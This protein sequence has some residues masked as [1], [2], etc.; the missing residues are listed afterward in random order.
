MSP[1]IHELLRTLGLALVAPL[2]LG[3]AHDV[4]R[5]KNGDVV[6]GRIEKIDDEKVYIDPTFSDEISIKFK[7]IASIETTRPVTITLDD[8]REIT[9][10]VELAP[11]GRMIVRT[12]PTRW[13][14]QQ[15][16]RRERFG[17]PPK[18]AEPKPAQE[19]LALADVSE[20]E[21]SYYRYEASVELGYNASSGNSD[22]SSLDLDAELEPSWGPNTLR[23]EADAERRTSNDSLS[24]DNWKLTFQYERDLPGRWLGYGVSS[25][26]SDPFQELDLRTIV[27]AGAGYEVYD[28]PT[29][30]LTFYAGPGYLKEA[31]SAGS[32]DRSSFGFVLATKF[33]QDLFS[34]D[35][36]L[37]HENQLVKTVGDSQFVAQTVQ[38][39]E[40]DLLSNLDLKLELDFDH[41]QD[42]PAGVEKK[43][44][45]RYVV[46]LEYEF[47]GDET[48]W[49]H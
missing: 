1:R 18:A 16:R 42:P 4:V 13:E 29:R 14:E 12:A 46:K 34:S 11:D 41:T 40:L 48:D 31:F 2:C 43:N 19:P 30:D 17:L 8:E 36:T 5:M 39:I 10:Y 28:T 44:D 26:E 33:E 15:R 21:L 38:G 27:A 37:Y 24:A 35:V 45:L 20:L 7:Y 49:F 6:H 25:F 3:A 23:F 22:S 32:R 9:G 47:E